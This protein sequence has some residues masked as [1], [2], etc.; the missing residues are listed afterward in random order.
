MSAVATPPMAPAIELRPLVAPEQTAALVRLHRATFPEA[1]ST[2]LGVRYLTA[3]FDWYRVTPSAVALVAWRDE[4]LGYV[5]GSPYGSERELY[6]KLLGTAALAFLGRPRLWLQSDVGRVARWRLASLGRATASERVSRLTAP[7]YLLGLIG[8]D[9]G[10]RRRGIAELLLDGFAVAA[11]ERG[12]RSLVLWVRRDAAEA[13]RL[14]E[15]RGWREGWEVWPDRSA[16]V[17]DA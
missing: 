3:F 11:R 7:T 1:E 16:Y 8:V 12:A 2:R 10:Q 5:L 9:P 6:R 13:R 4:S 17:R 14:Y 15:R